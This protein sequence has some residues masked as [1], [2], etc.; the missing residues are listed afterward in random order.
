VQRR[1]AA[2]VAA[3]H[4]D[5]PAAFTVLRVDLD[6]ALARA[7]DLS[8]RTGAPVDLPELL[9]KTVG[10]LHKSHPHIF[11]TR[12]PEGLVRAADA[13]AVG[14]TVDVGTGLYTP[15]IR[16]LP[17][18]SVSDIADTLAE[19]RMKALRTTLREDDLTGM[20]LLVALNTTPG[21]VTAQPIIPPG[22]TCALSL[23]AVHDEVVLAP[24]SATPR[25]RAVTDLGLAYDHRLING[26]EAA[27]FLSA[28]QQAL[29]TAAAA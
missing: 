19:L 27:A 2:V 25:T 9:I 7:R 4:R 10:D 18:M 6:T 15:V 29:N 28:I 13:P 20:N 12:T 11:A 14:V 24:G 16:D 1:V 5:I 23:A 3:S 21:V 22:V 8:E 17:A 26:A